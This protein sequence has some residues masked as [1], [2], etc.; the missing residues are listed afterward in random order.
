MGLRKHHQGLV[1][2][3][4]RI[5]A[6]RVDQQGRFWVEATGDPQHGDPDRCE[7]RLQRGG[8]RA[9]TGHAQ[10]GLHPRLP[11]DAPRRAPG[12]CAEPAERPARVPQ[13]ADLGHVGAG[14]QPPGE[15]VEHLRD[16]TRAFQPHRCTSTLRGSFAA[17]PGTSIRLTVCPTG[18]A[19]AAS[20]PVNALQRGQ[21]RSRGRRM[22]HLIRVAVD[23]C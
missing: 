6:R 4:D 15:F 21:R 13:D 22:A 20:A 1:G 19:S 23:E 18:R 5:E 12:R 8:C 16:V 17:A 14:A 10:H 11:R 9:A 7:I 2:A 3:A